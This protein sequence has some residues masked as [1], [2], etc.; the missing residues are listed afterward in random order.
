MWSYSTWNL[1]IDRG[2]VWK[3]N[4][5]E[6]GIQNSSDSHHLSHNEIF[7]WYVVVKKGRFCYVTVPYPLVVDSFSTQKFLMAHDA[8]LPHVEASENLPRQSCSWAALQYKVQTPP[9][10]VLCPWSWKDQLRSVQKWCSDDLYKNQIE[11]IYIKIIII[12]NLC[13]CFHR[14]EEVF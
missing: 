9:R 8:W 4:N 1:M 11:E 10:G 5:I 12:N 3:F 6:R 7:V 2:V 14:R 13:S